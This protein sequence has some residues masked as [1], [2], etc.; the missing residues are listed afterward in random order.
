MLAKLG[1][2]YGVTEFFSE[3]TAG[4]NTSVV[5]LLYNSIRNPHVNFRRSQKG[6]LTLQVSQ[7][8]AR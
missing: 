8:V 4:A 6:K 2:M 3:G 5:P 7:T 1:Q